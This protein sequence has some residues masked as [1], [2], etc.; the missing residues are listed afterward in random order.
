MF[1]FIQLAITCG[2]GRFATPLR[3]DTQ[4]TLYQRLSVAIDTALSGT[5]F[6]PFVIRGSIWRCHINH[7]LWC[8]FCAI[9]SAPANYGAARILTILLMVWAARVRP[10]ATDSV[11]VCWGSHR[12]TL[13]S[14]RSLITGDATR[15]LT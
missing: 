4:S 13:W 3:A 9:I 14:N 7:G 2:R 8:L 6:S 1:F 15:F 5:L 11:S 12:V 10:G